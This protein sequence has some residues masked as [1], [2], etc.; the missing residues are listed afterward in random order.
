MRVAR[1]GTRD[2]PPFRRRASLTRRLDGEC[3]AHSSDGARIRGE[4]YRDPARLD[5]LVRAQADTLLFAMNAG[6]Y[7]PDSTAQ[8]LLV[9]GGQTLHG[10]DTTQGPQPP[11]STNFYCH[12]NARSSW[13]ECEL[14]IRSTPE[15]VARPSNESDASLRADS[16]DAVTS[17]SPRATL[18]SEQPVAKFAERRRR[19]VGLHRRFRPSGG[20]GILRTREA[21][22][23]RVRCT[24][25]LD[26]DEVVSR[27]YAR[28]VTGPPSSGDAFA[29]L[30]A[31]LSKH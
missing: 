8:G 20:C 11:C 23:D 15:C 27:L 17:R 1:S 14:A 29:A 3:R 4:A 13:S 21:F 28:G 2:R 16:P 19:P 9:V 24:D 10:L 7:R 25:A 26:L 22:R 5:S 31:V 6:M 30:I 18:R 12:P